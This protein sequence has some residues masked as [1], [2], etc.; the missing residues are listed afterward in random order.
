MPDERRYG[1]GEP[2]EVSQGVL[3]L[4]FG[5]EVA[6][7]SLFFLN[8]RTVLLGSCG[9]RRRVP[10][11]WRTLVFEL[12]WLAALWLSERPAAGGQILTPLQTQ[13]TSAPGILMSTNWGPGTRGVTSP[14]VFERFNSHLGSLDAINITLSITIR[15]DYIMSFVATPLPTTLYLAT[16]ATSE[17]SV[18]ADP[19]KRA[20]LTD[21]PTV[22]LFASDGVA[23]LFGA[24]GTRQPVDFV[25]KTEASTGVWSSLLPVTDPHFI[26]P[27]VTEQSYS[28]T[29]DS[30]HAA[31]LLAS[32]IGTG[33]VDLPITATAFSSFY[34][35]SSNGGGAVLTK[36]R[37]TF[38]IQYLYTAASIA[39]PSSAFLLALGIV[40]G[41]LAYR[42]RRCATD[43]AGSD[44]A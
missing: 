39:E 20:L 44:G 33:T 12:A 41:I 35:D 27:T 15:N 21:G 32:F 43:A 7:K 11:R 5:I 37:A 10:M 29:L 1:A 42:F 13:S 34:S 17:P 8:D 3:F 9:P 30:S 19:A 38:T 24:P 22:S 18:L 6:N 4:E 23:Q 16:S 2:S 25:Q 31:A 40:G 36:A 28:R 14:L 26:P